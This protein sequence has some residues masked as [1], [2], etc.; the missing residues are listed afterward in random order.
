MPSFVHETLMKI[1]SII[2]SAQQCL[3]HHNYLHILHVMNTRSTLFLTYAQQSKSIEKR[4]A[5]LNTA[6]RGH[7]GT[8]TWPAHDGS[9]LPCIN[10]HHVSCSMIIGT[11][12]WQQPSLHQ[13]TI[14]CT[15]PWSKGMDRY[16]QV[17]RKL[18]M[19]H[20]E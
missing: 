13:C 7:R 18:Q 16:I 19:C 8:F 20:M 12:I 9:N 1:S 14:L 15:E 17:M 5:S 4:W 6:E 11:C 3:T 10:S 2:F